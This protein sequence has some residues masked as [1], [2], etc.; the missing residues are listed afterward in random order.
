MPIR[1]LVLVAIDDAPSME[2]LV[3][4]A[5]GLASRYDAD[6]QAI[7]VV[8]RAGGLWAA[9][10]HELRLRARVQALRPAIERAGAASFRVVTLRGA[11]DRALTAYA[12]LHPVRLII[13]GPHHGS[14]GPWRRG[15][16]TLGMMREAP[17]PTLVVPEAALTATPSWTRIVTAVDFAPA[18]WLALRTAASLAREH[19]ASLTLFHAV[20][21]PREMAFSGGDAL[22]VLDWLDTQTRTVGRRLQR[23]ATTLGASGADAVVLPGD[24]HR[25]LLRTAEEADATLIVMGV[26]PRSWFNAL[27]SRSTLRAVLRRAR[28]PV[29]VVPVPVSGASSGLDHVLDLGRAPLARVL[30]MRRWA[31]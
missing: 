4:Y 15:P 7:Q 31:A 6:L 27:V 18:S 23:L 11:A 21:S 28:V 10:G 9:P 17:A 14:A 2:S 26:S 8:S 22:R 1:P 3:T 5:A 25:G 29:L 24:A 20:A 30:P 12:R 19:D 16:A 13:V